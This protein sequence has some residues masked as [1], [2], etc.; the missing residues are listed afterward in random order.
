MLRDPLVVTLMEIPLRVHRIRS[1]M[2]RIL[3]GEGRNYEIR[4]ESCLS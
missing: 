2:L 4:G 1:A 3:K